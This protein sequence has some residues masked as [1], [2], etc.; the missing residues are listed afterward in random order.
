MRLMIMLVITVCMFAVGCAS[1]P[2]RNASASKAEQQPEAGRI[3]RLDGESVVLGEAASRPMSRQVFTRRIGQLIAAGQTN[4]AARLVY[5]YPDLARETIFASP[6]ISSKVRLAIAAWL[7]EL[8]KPQQGGWVMFVA[9][10]EENPSR[11]AAYQ[12]T[13]ASIWPAL[14]RGAFAEVA[15]LRLNPPTDSPVPWAQIDALLLRAT[16]MLAA[17]RPTQAAPLFNQASQLASA[18]DWRVATRAQ[19][20]AALSDSLANDPQSSQAQRTA[21]LEGVSLNDI[22]DPMTLRLILKTQTDMGSVLTT[23]PVRSVLAALGHLEMRRGSPQAALLAWRAAESKPGNDPSTDTLRLLQAESLIAL[24][25][26][27]AAIAMLTGLA[28]SRQQTQVRPNALV[29]LGLIHLKRNQVDIA[30]AMFKE[31]VNK[32]TPQ[33]HPAVHADVGLALLSTG[34]SRAG[35]LRLEEARAAYQAQGDQKA[36]Q[37]L[38]RNQLRYAESMGDSVLARQT[39]QALRNIRISQ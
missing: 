33:S 22:R 21:A 16:A 36:V 17:G 9:D 4:A 12:R 26:E 10:Q 14:K 19:L 25:Q 13:R 11:Y 18:W 24:Q 8:A 38:L 7:D 6:K 15:N 30:L 31:A 23:P 27:D 29:M 35:W 20:F 28:Q 2:S 39:R 32:S 34:Q 5:T 3:L 37:Q 1:T